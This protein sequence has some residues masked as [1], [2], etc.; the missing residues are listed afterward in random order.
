MKNQDKWTETKYTSNLPRRL[1][2]NKRNK[3]VNIS[4]WIITECTARLYELYLPL[5]ISGK[6]LDIGCGNCPLYGFYKDFISSVICVDWDNSYHE[7]PYNDISCDISKPLPL[8]D[9]MF[10]SI[11]ISDVLEHIS[12]PETVINESYRLLKENGTV[13]INVPFMYWI[14]ESPYDFYRYTEFGLKKLIEDAGFKIEIFAVV[15]GALETWSDITGKISIH[16]PIIG[17][18]LPKFLYHFS[19]SMKKINFIKTKF[20]YIDSLLPLG[21]FCVARKVSVT[22]P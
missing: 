7:N 8:E 3:S 11:L 21:Y 20:A 9:S 15:G 16:I 17:K 13:F 2:V 4:S 10:D 6:L 19:N 22:Q 12:N 1:S 5:F 18:F 14:H